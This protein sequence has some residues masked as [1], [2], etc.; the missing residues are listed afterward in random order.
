MHPMLRRYVR[1][2]FGGHLCPTAASCPAARP[3]KT[4]SVKLGAGQCRILPGEHSTLYSTETWPI[5][6]WG[7]MTCSQY[8]HSATREHLPPQRRR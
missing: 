7:V 6:L 1:P 3:G 8:D 5:D 2:A 4:M